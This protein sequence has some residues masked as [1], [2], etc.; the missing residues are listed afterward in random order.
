MM[1]M[2]VTNQLF[3]FAVAFAY[4]EETIVEHQKS[5]ERREKIK[6]NNKTAI[7]Q[8]WGFSHVYISIKW[9]V[10]MY[11]VRAC[12]CFLHYSKHKRAGEYLRVYFESVFCWI[13]K[14]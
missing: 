11:G 3:F 6:I 7:K 14:T 1:M 12:V 8:Y 2:T 5:I 13:C 4:F 9:H 10:C